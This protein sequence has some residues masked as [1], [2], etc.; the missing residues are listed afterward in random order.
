M[1]DILQTVSGD[2]ISHHW[3]VIRIIS[4]DKVIPVYFTQIANLQN[5]MFCRNVSNCIVSNQLGSHKIFSILLELLEMPNKIIPTL[6]NLCQIILK[7]FIYI[8]M[9]TI[10]L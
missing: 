7:H 9:T 5:L 10:S 3:V 2:N 1:D 4:F 6:D 8:K